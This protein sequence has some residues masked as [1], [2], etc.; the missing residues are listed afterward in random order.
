MLGLV[1]SLPAHSR[2]CIWER[3]SPD[4]RSLANAPMILRFAGRREIYFGERL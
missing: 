3:R 4:S 2:G 1:L